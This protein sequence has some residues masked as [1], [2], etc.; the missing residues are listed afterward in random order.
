MIM[1]NIKFIDEKF[2]TVPSTSSNRIKL[3][4]D[5]FKR[6]YGKFRLSLSASKREIEKKYRILSI[7]GGPTIYGKS[8]AIKLKRGMYDNVS[9]NYGRER[10]VFGEEI[11]KDIPSEEITKN[12]PSFDDQVAVA[13][14]DTSSEPTNIFKED[15]ADTLSRGFERLER[16]KQ[17][18]DLADAS[19]ADVESENVVESTSDDISNENIVDA[20]SESN[21]EVE[22]EAVVDDIPSEVTVGMISENNLEV[23]NEV[24]EDVSHETS[25]F[26]DKI[27]ESNEDV[28]TTGFSD[29]VLGGI[30]SNVRKIDD[31]GNL[32]ESYGVVSDNNENNAVRDDIVVIPPRVEDIPTK[33]YV[34]ENENVEAKKPSTISNFEALKQ[35]LLKVKKAFVSS[36]D[37]LANTEERRRKAEEAARVRRLEAEKVKEEYRRQC[38]LAI[39]Q[40]NA[41]KNAIAK[42]EAEQRAAEEDYQIKT[43]FCE[44]QISEKESYESMIDEIQNMMHDSNNVSEVHGLSR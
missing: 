39:E 2:D 3:R 5:S 30:V 37:S 6:I 33:D 14:S 34:S 17:N 38:D 11:T 18:V 32:K 26:G 12:I 29:S 25:I 1:D 20:V 42:N 4:E 35:E 28:S 44:E 15:I 36:K 40:I 9:S 23:E 27:D 24:T 41:L 31:N 16:E 8:R 43:N 19:V 13:A 7:N 22:P 10:G 21:T